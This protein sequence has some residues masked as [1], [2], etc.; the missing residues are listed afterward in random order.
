MILKQLRQIFIIITNPMHNLI[1]G[2]VGCAKSSIPPD[3]MCQM[4]HPTRCHEPDQTSRLMSF[5]QNQ[6][7]HQ[8]SHSRTN[9]PPDVVWQ[10]KHH[11]RCHEPEH[12]C[13]QMSWAKVFLLTIFIFNIQHITT[14]NNKLSVSYHHQWQILRL[15]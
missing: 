1:F 13:H 9:I 11:T 2:L 6:A 4:K 12:T 5:A 7:S 3:V 14:I 10:I 15:L 8:M